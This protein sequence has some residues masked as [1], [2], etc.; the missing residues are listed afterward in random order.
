MGRIAEALKRAQEERLRKREAAPGGLPAGAAREG[1][2]D[3]GA[4]ATDAA[5]SPASRFGA[6]FDLPAMPRPFIVSAAPLPPESVDRRLVSFHEPSLVV[7]EKYRAIRTRLLTANPD[8][9]SRIYAVA[10]SL[11]GEG[12]SVSAGNLGFCFA[13][14]RHLRVAVVDCDLRRR[15]LSG[16]FSATDKPGLADVI[17]GDRPLSEVCLPVVRGNLHLIPSGDPAGESPSDLFGGSRL[18][19]IFQEIRERF[20]YAL[21]D[22]PPMDAFADIG[23]VAPLCHSTLIVI[24]LNSTPEGVLRRCVRM[25]Q[26]NR[27]SIA[28]SILVGECH[29]G[30][31]RPESSDYYNPLAAEA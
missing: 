10:S 22:T 7:S 28:G 14:L 24:R 16:L 25:L 20:H 21:V 13:E 29:N 12:R 8:G 26:A 9:S 30:L 27:I 2:A 5:T 3:A 6:I 31:D 1:A 4:R 19:S 11:H 17:R 15:G 23:L 18:A